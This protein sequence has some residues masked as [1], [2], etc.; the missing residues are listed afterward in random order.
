VVVPAG[1]LRGA[2]QPALEAETLPPR[3][4]V[5]V[6]VLLIDDERAIREATS[7]LLRPLQV[8]VLAAATI[9]EA[10]DLVRRASAPIDMILSDWRLRGSET[11][12]QAVREVR[13][14]CGPSTPAVLI[15]GDTSAEVLKQAH[16]NGLV[17]L[18][19]PLQP[20]ELLRLIGRLER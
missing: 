5:R 17:I 20:R 1:D 7:E 6:T 2:A 13:K 18:H 9:A 14:L 19:K 10:V 12:V 11:G 8:D 3:T 16:Q 15:T 4:D